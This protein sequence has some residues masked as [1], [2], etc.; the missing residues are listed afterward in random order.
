MM[1]IGIHNLKTCRHKLVRWNTRGPSSLGTKHCMS[2][3]EQKGNDN[4]QQ[5]YKEQLEELQN[6]R[7]NLFMFSEEEVKMWS[8]FRENS[9]ID[10]SKYD[11]SNMSLDETINKLRKTKDLENK[12]YIC[13][14]S[15]PFTH[16]KT[17]NLDGDNYAASMVD[18]GEKK[19]TRRVA[20]AQS[21]VI[22]PPEVMSAFQ[23]LDSKQSSGEMVGPKGPIFAT[24]RI[25][26]IMGAKRTSELIPLCHPLPL[27]KINV[28]IRIEDNIAIIEC[29]CRV[30]HKTGMY[31]F[32]IA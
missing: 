2:T 16:L 24:A 18:V 29:E 20:V 32:S 3:D 10:D 25:A 15:N 7:E 26:G 19:I 14:K 5:I 1:R 6:E 12:N 28:D 22:F 23:M 30:S 8:S 27:E 31:P 21:R 13:N 9:S 17:S 11:H 4:Y